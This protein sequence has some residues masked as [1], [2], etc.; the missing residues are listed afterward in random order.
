MTGLEG[1]N[2]NAFGGGQEPSQ[3]TNLTNPFDPPAER[4]PVPHEKTRTE[5]LREFFDA[6]E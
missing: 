5:E 4:Q 6:E 3:E 2:F 1:L